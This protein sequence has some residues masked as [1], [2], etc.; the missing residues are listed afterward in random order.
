MPAD[1][2]QYC[3]MKKDDTDVKREMVDSEGKWG[4]VV[5]FFFFKYIHLFPLAY[6]NSGSL[7]HTQG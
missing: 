6:S 5:C 3:V 2:L 1:K 4:F 7:W